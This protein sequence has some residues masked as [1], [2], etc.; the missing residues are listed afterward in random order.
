MA[1]GVGFV[2]ISSNSVRS[3]VKP[4]LH[5]GKQIEGGAGCLACTGRGG[6]AGG[7]TTTAGD[8]GKLC[9]Q[10]LASVSSSVGVSIRQRKL[11]VGL[12]NDSLQRFGAPPF[13]SAGCSLGRGHGARQVGNVLGVLCPGRCM[14]G[15]L[16]GQSPRLQAS[17]CNG[18][19]KGCYQSPLDHS[20][21]LYFGAR[22]TRTSNTWW[23]LMSQADRPLYRG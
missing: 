7:D 2:S 5:V 20:Q 16:G 4:A 22:V 13:F 8:G 15:L 18:N 19:G 6:I 9:A 23:R 3:L 21:P 1:G 14:I 17:C 12:I 11:L 10:P